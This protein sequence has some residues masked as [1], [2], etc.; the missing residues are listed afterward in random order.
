MGSLI[1][2]SVVLDKIGQVQEYKKKYKF[3]NKARKEGGINRK[4]FVLHVKVLL[5]P[6]KASHSQIKMIYAEQNQLIK[7]PYITLVEI[8]CLGWA[9]HSQIK[10][11]YVEQNQLSKIHLGHPSLLTC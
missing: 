11:L 8:I 5:H 6:E 2:C 9:S 7:I 3:G 10:M 1:G 4:T